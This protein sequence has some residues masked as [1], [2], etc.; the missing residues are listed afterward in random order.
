MTR[1]P[2]PSTAL[3]GCL[4]AA[5]VVLAGCAAGSDAVARDEPTPVAS[6]PSPTAGAHPA[7][8]ATSYAYTLSISCYCPDPGPVRVVVDHDRVTSATYL[9]RE[10]GDDLGGL[11]EQPVGGK[12]SGLEQPEPGSPADA[13]YR[14]TIDDLIG[15]ADD[16]DAAHVEVDWPT[17]QAYPSS[18]Y[19][20]RDEQVADEEMTWTI[21]DVVPPPR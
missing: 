14:R 8:E 6:T 9:G 20:D 2:G 5:T 4:A 15:Y 12:G 18:I 3:L 16:P 1:A 7:F 21:S 19:V 11:G 13:A 10:V 17:G